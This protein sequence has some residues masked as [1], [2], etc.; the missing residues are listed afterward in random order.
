MEKDFYSRFGQTLRKA[1][2]ASGLSQ[3]HLGKGVGLNRTSVSNI[4][5][6]RQKILLHVS[7][8]RMSW[9][10]CCSMIWMI[11]TWTVAS[12]CAFAAMYPVS[13]LIT[14]KWRQPGSRRSC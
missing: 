13:A 4:E 2:K 14:T 3:E 5:K 1:R 6:G 8:S 11:C 7:R 10:T 9:S 12:W